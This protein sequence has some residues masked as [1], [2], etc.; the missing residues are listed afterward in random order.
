MCTIMLKLNPKRFRGLMAA[1]IG[2]YL[3][4]ALFVVLAGVFLARSAD[5]IAEITGLGR[6]F[7]GSI[8]LAG[9]TS[10]PE[11]IV[12]M[13]AI[14][15][16]EPNLAVGDLLGSSLFNLLILALIDSFYKKEYSLFSPNYVHHSMAV[17]LSILLTSIL[18][19]GLL[20]NIH[21]SI[22]NVGIFSWTI[23]IVYLWGFILI[24]K[25]DS[26]K[27]NLMNK[28]I[29]FPWISLLKSLFVFAISAA[30]LT[31]IAPRLVDLADQIAVQGNL[32]KSFVGTTLIALTTSLPEL[33]ATLTA[34]K[35]G[36]ADLALA[37]IFGSNTFNMMLLIPLDIMRPGALLAEVNSKNA[38]TAFT[39][40]FSSCVVLMSYSRRTQERKSFWEPSSQL[41]LLSIIMSLYLLFITKGH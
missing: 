37:N 14:I 19:L 24:Y 1:L 15:I 30:L 22:F 41:I 16:N 32:G 6:L 5:T 29:P 4:Y 25:T 36:S 23:G 28:E 40:I 3:F 33:A 2:E 38:I 34:F 20:S 17:L 8:L 31:L 12:D 18:G 27:S 7:I 39:V 21:Y 11:L 26:E 9:A 35:I 10:L 13:N